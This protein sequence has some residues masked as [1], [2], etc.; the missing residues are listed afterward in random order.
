VI[1][2]ALARVCDVIELQAQS[3]ERDTRTYAA[4]VRAAAGQAR[5]A[6]PRVDSRGGRR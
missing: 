5:G 6:N 2:S 4:F 1:A 3:L